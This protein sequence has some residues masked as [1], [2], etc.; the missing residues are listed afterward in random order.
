MRPMRTSYS[1]LLL[2]T[3]LTLG[4]AHSYD[5]DLQAGDAPATRLTPEA[6]IYVARPADGAYGTTVYPQSGTMTAMAV[7]SA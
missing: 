3:L 2:A 6:T 7:T 4:C 5:V 1:L